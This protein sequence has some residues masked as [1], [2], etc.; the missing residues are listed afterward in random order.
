MNRIPCRRCLL[1][2]VGDEALLAQVRDWKDAI[3]RSQRAPAEC[4][5]E[6]LACCQRCDHLLNGMC[7]LCGCFVEV[8]AARAVVHCAGTPPQW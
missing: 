8:R 3:P 5:R 6:R 2:A 1:E 4:Y 7:M